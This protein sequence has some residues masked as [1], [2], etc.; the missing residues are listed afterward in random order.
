MP[1]IVGRLFTVKAPVAVTLPPSVFVTVTS[2]APVVA[3]DETV[4]L[5]VS[6][7]ADVT[8][9]GP[10]TVMPVPENETVAPETKPVPEMAT[11]SLAAPWP[12]LLGV[13]VVIVGADTMVSPPASVCSCE[14]RLVK[15]T[16]RT[17]GAAESL[18]V[19]LAVALVGLTYCT[20]VTV[21]PAPSTMT[22][23]PRAKFVPV[24]VTTWSVAR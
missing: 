19:N 22:E 5:A 1:E 10:L 21:T 18:T 7:V 11:F 15:V 13:T 6:C 17:P 3:V 12:R 16:L 4:M 8:T 9:T 23:A 20:S 2:R 14:S 24:R